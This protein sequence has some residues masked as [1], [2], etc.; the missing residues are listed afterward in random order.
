M[1]V[2]T[3]LRQEVAARHAHGVAVDNRPHAFAFHDEPEGVLGVAVLG[4]VFSRHQVLDR[5]PQRGRGERPA[6]QRRV[7]QRDGA[8]F[9]AAPDGND[10]AGLR[11]KRLQPVPAP[12]MRCG[13]GLG[14]Q[15][16][17]VAD[18]RPQRHQ[19]FLLETSVQLLQRR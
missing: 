7:G 18:F 2:P 16:H 14:M 17:Q 4:C 11:R 12:K 10:L 5:G 9:T 1:P 19:Q 15:R 3:R 13:L 6:A 8:A